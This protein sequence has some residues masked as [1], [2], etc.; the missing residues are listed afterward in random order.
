MMMFIMALSVR[1]SVRTQ[2]SPCWSNYCQGLY[3]SFLRCLKMSACKVLSVTEAAVANHCTFVL[4]VARL[5]VMA[6]T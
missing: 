4:K 2:K 5:S 6:N 1:E 3:N